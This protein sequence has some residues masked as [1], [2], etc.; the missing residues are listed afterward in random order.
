[1][2]ARPRS[3]VWQ[4]Q[5]DIKQPAEEPSRPFAYDD[6]SRDET[7]DMQRTLD[8]MTRESELPDPFAKRFRIDLEDLL[9]A[10]REW[11]PMSGTLRPTRSMKWT[12]PYLT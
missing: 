1:V 8:G 9:A 12:H 2:H 11:L 10:E 5:V 7:I 6:D 4:S 3:S